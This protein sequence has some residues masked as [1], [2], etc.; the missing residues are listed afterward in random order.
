VVLQVQTIP[1]AQTPP[2]PLP[3]LLAGFFTRIP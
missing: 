3:S 1:S 2:L